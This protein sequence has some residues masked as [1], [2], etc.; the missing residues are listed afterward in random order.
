MQKM[1]A[2]KNNKEEVAYDLIVVGGGASGMMAAAHAAVGGARVLLLEKN[3]ELGKKLKITGGGRCNITNAESNTRQLLSHYGEHGKYLFSAFAKFDNL[4]AMKWFTEQGLGL[5]EEDRGR[6]FPVSERAYDVFSVL[7]NCLKEGGVKVRLKTTVT[8]ILHTDKEISGI[9]IGK[10]ILTAKNYLLATGGLSHPETG[11]TGDGFNWLQGLGLPVLKPSPSVVPLKVKEEWVKK[12][13]GVILKEVKIIF[14][15][16]QKKQFSLTGNILC[17]HFGISGPLILNAAARVKDLLEEGEVIATID[18]QPKLDDYALNQKLQT[19]FS[20]HKN[21]NLKNIFNEFGPLGVGS[22][23]LPLV[24]G[25]DI[26]KKV[27]SI[28]VSERQML[29]KT[30]KALPLTIVSL[31]GFEKAVITDGGLDL[32]AIDMRTMRVKKYQNLLVTGDLLNIRRPSGGYSLQLCWTTG[33]IAG[34]E[35]KI[36]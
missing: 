26:D 13:A 5:K 1:S 6:V 7:D 30:L 35:I 12:L 3:S 14:F 18:T 16:K 2:D 4:A 11:S 17:T 8:K 21:K 27:H 29:V 25:L 32:D 33:F 24:S 36:N 34:E 20:E 9:Q 10:E 22:V 19:I 28:T 31:M 23:I 15:V